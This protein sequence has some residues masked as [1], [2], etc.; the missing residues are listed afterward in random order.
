[1]KGW[2]YPEYPGVGNR[3]F[4]EDAILGRR[5]VPNSGCNYKDSPDPNFDR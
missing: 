2:M 4:A 5:T 1:M 3:L